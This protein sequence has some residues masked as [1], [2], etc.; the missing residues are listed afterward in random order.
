MT[1]SAT[2]TM[3]LP[4]M[5][6]TQFPHYTHTHVRPS[7]G[8]MWCPAGDGATSGLEERETLQCSPRLDFH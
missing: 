1:F 6:G 4:V 2:H 3:S 5:S 7:S 8:V